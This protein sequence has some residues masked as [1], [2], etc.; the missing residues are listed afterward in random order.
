[1]EPGHRSKQCPLISYMYHAHL[2]TI[3]A[4][5]NQR[6]SNSDLA[7]VR[8]QPRSGTIPGKQPGCGCTWLKGNR[9]ESQ[10][11]SLGLGDKNQPLT[12]LFSDVEKSSVFANSSLQIICCELAFEGTWYPWVGPGE[13]SASKAGST[14]VVTRKFLQI[15]ALFVS[16]FRDYHRYSSYNNKSL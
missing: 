6:P 12:N 15:R 10:A 11:D 4:R 9:H 16:S 5:T 3:L 7:V 8:G 1:M 14:R 2:G 13:S